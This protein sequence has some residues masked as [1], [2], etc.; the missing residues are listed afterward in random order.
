VAFSYDEGRSWV[1]MAVDIPGTNRTFTF[2]ASQIPESTGE[3]IVRVFVS[4]G[5]NTAYDDV[6]GLAR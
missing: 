5:L 6:T 3:G 1:P 2:D 4:D